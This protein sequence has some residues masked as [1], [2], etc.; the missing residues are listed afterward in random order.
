VKTWDPEAWQQPEAPAPGADKPQG[1]PRPGLEPR[2]PTPEE[3][4]ACT[5]EKLELIDG[6]VLGEENLLLLLLTSMGL[7]RAAELV[8]LKLWRSAAAPA[9][10]AVPLGRPHAKRKRK[11]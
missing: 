11:P 2:R 3:F 7:R 8:G 6:H 10:W 5:P 1:S 9:R 4:S